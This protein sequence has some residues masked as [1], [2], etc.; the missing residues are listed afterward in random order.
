MQSIKLFKCKCGGDMYDLPYH[1]TDRT[2]IHNYRCGK[3][4]SHYNNGVWYTK[5]QWEDAIENCYL[6]KPPNS[7]R[8]IEVK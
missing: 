5:E 6:V 1:D 4:D 8:F 7:F 2:V 3:C